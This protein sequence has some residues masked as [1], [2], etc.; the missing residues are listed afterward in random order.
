[1]LLASDRSTNSVKNS[2]LQDDLGSSLLVRLAVGE[3]LIIDR[4]YYAGNVPNCLQFNI[5]IRL[6]I[7]IEHDQCP[8][9]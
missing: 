1:M 8:I 5:R 3:Y 6:F 7:F 2:V 4:I 9:D